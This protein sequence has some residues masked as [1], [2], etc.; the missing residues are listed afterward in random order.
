MTPEQFGLT[1]ETTQAISGGIF[2]AGAREYLRPARS[3]TKRILGAALCIGGGWMFGDDLH[4][5]LGIGLQVA[6]ATAGVIC[7][8]AAEGLLKA[9]ERADVLAFL[10]KG[11]TA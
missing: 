10:K 5:Y 7:I 1:S 8:G 11:P 3:L 2:A 6:S 4:A 9:I